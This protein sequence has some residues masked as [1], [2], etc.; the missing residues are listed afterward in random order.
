M[1]ER[2]DLAKAKLPQDADEPRVNEVKFS[3]FDPMMVMTLGGALPERAL[4]A[5]AKRPE[6]TASKSLAGVLEV[7]IVGTREEVLE[8]IVDP[9]AME[10]YGLSPADVLNFVERNN[11][12]VAAG[13][14]QGEQGRFAIKVP[15]VIESPEDV[16]QPADQGG[17]RSRRALPRHRRGAP[18][19]QGPGKLRPAERQPVAGHRGGRSAPARTCS[20]TVADVR[21]IVA[22]VQQAWPPGIELTYSRDKSQWV[23][24]GHRQPGQQRGGG[25]RAGV[26]RA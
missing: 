14:V 21:E 18:H 1:R 23:A 24:E 10:S 20:I 12:L 4:L 17:R 2:V 5:V 16:L 7:N 25:H 8:I 19:L 9:L 11:R 6:Q 15:G 26:H 3:R 22:Q 13:A